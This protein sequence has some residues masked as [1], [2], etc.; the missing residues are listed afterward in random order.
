[1]EVN[2]L[3]KLMKKKDVCKQGKECAARRPVEQNKF[4]EVIKRF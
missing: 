3:I 4:E 1:M 2:E